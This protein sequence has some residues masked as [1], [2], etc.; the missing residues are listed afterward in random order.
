MTNILTHVICED[1]DNVRLFDGARVEGAA[2]EGVGGEEE[3]EEL[4]GGH[5]PQL[6][7]H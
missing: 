4:D 5:L 1:E 2:E 3:E 6:P 7:G